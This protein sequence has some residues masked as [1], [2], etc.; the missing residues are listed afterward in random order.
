MRGEF[1]GLIHIH[2]DMNAP[3][4]EDHLLIETA[5]MKMNTK[6]MY[7]TAP[8]HFGW[9]TSAAATNSKFAS[10]PTSI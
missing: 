8:R 10:W 2:S 3:G 5:D 1:P 6:L 7:T 4:P 9:A